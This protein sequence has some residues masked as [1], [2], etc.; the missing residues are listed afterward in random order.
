MLETNGDRPLAK[1]AETLW[2]PCEEQ[3]SHLERGKKR[4][5]GRGERRRGIN[6]SM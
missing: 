5:G 1:V 3:V 4:V 6:Q 2:L